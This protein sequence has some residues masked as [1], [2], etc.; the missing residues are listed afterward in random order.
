[1]TSLQIPYAF[2]ND[3]LPVS[4]QVAEKG[5]DFSCPTC[6]SAVILKRGDI[7]VPHFAHKSD[8]KCSSEGVRH[9]V[10]KQMIY[11]MY[12]RSI[13][14]PMASIG[15]VRKCPNCSQYAIYTQGR[16]GYD[17]DVKCEVDVSGYRVD[18]ALF[19]NG[20]PAY[21]I[22]VRD[23][24]PVDD[25][26]WAA[27]KELRFPCIE[28]EAK[29]VIRMWE[30]DI[31]AW[32]PCIP[33]LL[34]PMRLDLKAIKHNLHIF[35]DQLH[36]IHCNECDEGINHQEMDEPVQEVDESIPEE[37]RAEILNEMDRQVPRLLARELSSIL[38]M[39]LKK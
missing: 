14:T 8:T 35:N 33:G 39:Q 19:R 32:K 20:K 36:R 28:V 23:T 26:K 29:D 2:T 31:N 34:W 21:G 15:V 37:V 10:A 18:I 11:L 12:R 27:F 9:K 24:H 25:V 22:E 4:P 7:R 17:D 13:D 16:T 30:Y 38:S 5:Q 1:M 3:K 6:D